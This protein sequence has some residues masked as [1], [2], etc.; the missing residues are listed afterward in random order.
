MIIDLFGPKA[1]K[2]FNRVSRSFRGKAVPEGICDEAF[3]KW[4]LK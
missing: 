4:V 2:E 1:D 3:G